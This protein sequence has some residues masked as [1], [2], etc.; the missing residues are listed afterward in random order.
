VP[1]LLAIVSFYNTIVN[2]AAADAGR[3]TWTP[4]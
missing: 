1:S 3:A 4:T 2:V